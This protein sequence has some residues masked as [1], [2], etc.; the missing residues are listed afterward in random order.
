MDHNISFAVWKL[1]V[2]ENYWYILGLSIM[3]DFNYKIDLV[4]MV[5]IHLKKGYAFKI[6][7]S[8]IFYIIITL[9]KQRGVLFNVNFYVLIMLFIIFKFKYDMF[10]LIKT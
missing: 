5:V 10:G 7:Y 3:Y 4:L 8:L 1:F 6:C 9:I 2:I